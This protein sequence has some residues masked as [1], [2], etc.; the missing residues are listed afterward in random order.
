MAY[1]FTNTGFAWTKTG[2]DP[3]ADERALGLQG[4]MALPAQFVN[5]QWTKTY[6]AI[7]EIQQVLTDMSQG[8][9]KE[10]KSIAVGTESTAGTE[11]SAAI[12][13][14]VTSASGVVVVGKWNKPVTSIAGDSNSGDLFVVG[15][16]MTSGAKANALRVTGNGDVMGTKAFIA[17]GADYAEMFEWLD[18]NKENEDR[19]GLFVTLD[20]DKIRIAEKGDYIA[21]V[22]SATPSILGDAYTEDW[23]GKYKTD[24]FGEKVLEN[25]SFVLSDDFDEDMDETYTGRNKRPEWAAVGLVGKLIV[26]DDGTCKVN[27]SCECEAGG[28]ATAAE[29]GYRVMKRIDETHV[30]IL[31]K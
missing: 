24:I 4:G 23:Q 28:K 5:Q 14:K 9:D 21:G 1:T 16:G 10:L 18:G 8:G 25:G 19:R 2:S 31:L 13:N 30:Q 26:C 6:K 7:Q 12:G 29:T 20:G 17:S 22:I 27:G 15:N 11:N 3:T